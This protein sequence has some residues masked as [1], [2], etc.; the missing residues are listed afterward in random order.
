MSEFVNLDA[1]WL[2]DLA[3]QEAVDLD[4]DGQWDEACVR[5]LVI[6][7]RLEKLDEANRNLQANGNSVG[8]FERGVKAERE[9]IFGR[10]N[11]PLQS[12]EVN[13][14]LR[15]AVLAS[16]RPVKKVTAIKPPKE[17]GKKLDRGT[18]DAVIAGLKID[19]TKLGV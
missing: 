1:K 2:K 14:Q 13:E 17:P 11:L 18:L 9:R 12:V 10:T 6:A 19:L 16:T 7:E 5:L 3:S 4:F 15:A 8:E